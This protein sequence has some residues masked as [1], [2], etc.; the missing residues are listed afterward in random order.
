MTYQ[1][2]TPVNCGPKLIQEITGL[3]YEQV[4]ADWPGGWLESGNS[5]LGIPND[6][7]IE[8]FVFL[9]KK[10]FKFRI[11]SDMQILSKGC[12]PAKTVILLHKKAD[13]CANWWQRFWTPMVSQH[14]V[15][16]RE[17]TEIGIS[18]NTGLADQPVWSMTHKQ[19]RDR[20][21]AGW[22]NCAYEIGP[23]FRTKVSYWQRLIAK[24]T[25]RWV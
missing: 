17:V 14:W 13:K 4:I 7:P 2:T 18:F 16:L 11:I 10:G 25:G 20:Y 9:E 22:P 3:P 8:H 12:V 1:M 15:Q 24:I 21:R 5:R 23:V 19:F 6:T